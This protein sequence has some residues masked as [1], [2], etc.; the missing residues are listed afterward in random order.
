MTLWVFLFIFIHDRVME[1]TREI[2]HL[3]DHFTYRKIIKFTLGTVLMMIFSS[4]YWI[5]DGFFISNYIST[6]AFA[7]VNLIFP[8]IM[9]VACIGFMFGAGGAALV[10][11][12][13]GEKKDE[14]ANH[15]FALITYVALGT[16]IVFSIVFFFLV[17][18]IA[19]SFAA[20]NLVNA[21]EEMID[22]AVRYGRIM[23]GGISLYVM[24]SFFHSFFAVS[25]RNDLGFLFTFASGVL[26]M[27]LDYLL[28]GVAGMQIEGAAIASLS[29]MAISAIGP[30]IYF[31][32][33]KKNCI[34]LCK[35]LFS[36][37]DITKTLTNGFSEF[38]SNI[39]ASIISIVFNIQLL[40]YIGE[41]GVAAY[42]VI[43]YV[44]F[45]FFAIFIGYSVAI[46]PVI[47]YN[48]GAKNGKELS[49]ILRKSFVI[50][51]IVGIA[52]LGL[53]I[54]FARP[55]AEIFTAGNPALQDLSV[56]AMIIFSF[57]YL[58]TGYSM[59][60]SS[61]FTALNNGLIS[62]I[63]SFFRTLVFQLT[64]VFVLPLMFGTDGI[65]YSIVVA[66]VLSM[67]M[68]IVFMIIFQKRYG[69]SM[70]PFR[71]KE[72]REKE[73]SGDVAE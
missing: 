10:S 6:S 66:E 53:A 38:V 52:M 23:I 41:S 34:H 61:F 48:Y 67:V 24:Q 35:P 43:G 44:C 5:V 62:A 27:L 42:G 3:S 16:G 47:G 51:E 71:I 17:R 8:V 64:A 72:R 60:G 7:G 29:G 31:Y 56:H 11:K 33:S 18:P 30:F 45:V 40:K 14:E 50:V 2:I 21:T 37:K 22:N 65:W 73:T 19:Q 9:A 68:T 15:T 54:G 49:N 69:Y 55:I 57:C 63:I 58:F 12:K 13:L 36:I 26:N 28:I 59:F 39:S 4:I 70:D 25:E 1:M 46:T 32:L 20:I